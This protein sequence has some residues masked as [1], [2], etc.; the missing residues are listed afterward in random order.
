[1]TPS[2]EES[3]QWDKVRNKDNDASQNTAT[4]QT[5]QEANHQNQQE[6][7]PADLSSQEPLVLTHK[8]IR[9]PMAEQMAPAETKKDRVHL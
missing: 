3:A 7:Q 6:T 1:M 2:A 5:D 4:D 8:T 9:H